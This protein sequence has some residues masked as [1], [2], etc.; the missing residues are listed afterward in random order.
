MGDA[1]IINNF[2][3]QSKVF[4]PVLVFFASGEARCVK[5][6]G[7]YGVVKSAFVMGTLLV[8]AF[9]SCRWEFQFQENRPQ[10]Q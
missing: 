2:S 7:V 3:K 6:C 8:S 9:R 10:S 1:L 4:P 5:Q